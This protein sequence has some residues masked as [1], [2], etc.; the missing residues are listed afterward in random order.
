MLVKGGIN[1]QRFSFEA[2][3]AAWIVLVLASIAFCFVCLHHAFPC[4]L[5]VAF[6]ASYVGPYM[7]GCR[8][9]TK[10]WPI[11]ISGAILATSAIAGKCWG[12]LPISD[13]LTLLFAMLCST[14]VALKIGLSWK[15]RRDSTPQ[16]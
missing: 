2:V 16:A 1:M 3:E 15:V 6:L 7:I 5:I 4:N 8:A 13:Y 14:A 11:L 9:S 10:H 12:S